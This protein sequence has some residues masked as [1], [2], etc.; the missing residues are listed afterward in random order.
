[1]D[2]ISEQ[3]PITVYAI[4]AFFSIATVLFSIGRFFFN[5]TRDNIIRLYSELKEERNAR[6]EV[7]RKLHEEIGY[8][9]G[10]ESK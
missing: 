10:K 9:K 3:S 7:D 4:L 2:P 8:R 1:M 5:Y 6:M